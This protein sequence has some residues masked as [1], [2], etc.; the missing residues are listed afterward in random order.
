MHQQAKP[1]P[2]KIKKK[3][4]TYN[5]VNSIF[6]LFFPP[7][8]SSN[9]KERAQNLDGLALPDERQGFI[10]DETH[11]PEAEAAVPGCPVE[12][13]QPDVHLPGLGVEGHVGVP[14]DR[15]R[16]HLGSVVKSA[17]LSNYRV[18]WTNGFGFDVS[19]CAV[20]MAV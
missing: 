4:A 10:G 7:S 15:R 11:E 3:L 5:A 18:V 14:V 17:G 20:W 16:E 12:G 9:D 13:R 6:L 8:S 1:S 2:T 19:S